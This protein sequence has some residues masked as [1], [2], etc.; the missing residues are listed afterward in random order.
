MADSGV[1]LSL[2][3]IGKRYPGVV[4]LTDFT[5]EL[6]AGEVVGLL[7]ENGAGK[8]TLVKIL[9]GA[10]APST[11]EIVLAGKR[12]AFAS[13]TDALAAGIATV[14]QESMLVPNLTVAANIL[15]GREPALG[16]WFGPLRRAMLRRLA[17]AAIR[18]SGFNLDPDQ[19]VSDLTSAGRQLVEFTRAL[20]LAARVVILDEPTSALTAEETASLFVAVRRL[21]A[22]GIAVIYITHRLDEVAEICHRVLVLRDGHLVGTLAGNAAQHDLVRMMVGREVAALFPDKTAS[23]TGGPPLLTVRGLR[24]RRVGP[25]DLDLG[26]GEVVGLVGLL[27]SAQES[28]GRAIFGAIRPDAGTIA[29]SG[30]PQRLGDPTAAAAA[31]MA[32]LGADRQREGVVPTMT[33]RGNLSL[34][35][36]PRVSTGPLVWAGR[37]RRFTDTLRRDYAIRSYST[38]QPMDT[39]SGGN[40]QKALL[41]RWLATKPKVLVL[42]EPTHGI[43][44]GAKEEIYRIIRGLA[45]DGKGI[46]VVSS[47]THEIAGLCDRVIGFNRV[48]VVGE[49][50]GA[51][52]TPEAIV[53]LTVQHGTAEAEHEVAA[54]DLG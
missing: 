6:R 14:F 10:T 1:I 40:Q 49:L 19:L 29:L 30:R 36:L 46:I 16:G 23:S 3:G 28:V 44:V 7:G 39:L 15:L 17:E 25:V 31:G 43:D 20:D 53:S 8:S 35:S 38:A 54:A 51:A 50:R 37:E 52:V 12:V 45:R 32:F 5:A 26:A 41:A 42:E 4:A 27:G 47:D 21:A 13:P 22:A 34:C 48:G 2:R 18:R 33:L 11:G 24:V 9:S